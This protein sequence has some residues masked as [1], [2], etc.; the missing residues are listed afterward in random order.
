MAKVQSVPS[1]QSPMVP[2]ITVK[3]APKAI[4]FYKKAFGAQEAFRLV[5]SGS[6]KVGH[7]ELRV[8]GALFSLNDE[9]PDWG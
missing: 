3:N 8:E 7:A 4:D 5:E 1:D 6:G 2:Q 9:Y